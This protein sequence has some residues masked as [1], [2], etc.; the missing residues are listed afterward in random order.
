MSYTAPIAS[1]YGLIQSAADYSTATGQY[2]LVTATSSGIA[3]QT[4]R[5][6][7]VMGTLCNTPTSGT[8]ADVGT[9]GVQKVQCGSTHTLITVGSRLFCSTASLALSSG[10]GSSEANYI[11]GRS[12][13]TLAADTSGVIAVLMTHEGQGSSSG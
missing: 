11:F 3:Q 10:D 2:T 9:W 13:E 4:T 6:G 12:L 5:G 7:F 8:A 1:N